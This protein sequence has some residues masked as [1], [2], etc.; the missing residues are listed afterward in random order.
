[1]RASLRRHSLLLFFVLAF[2]LSWWPWPFILL[3]PSSAPLLHFGVLFAALITVAV[4]HGRAGIRSLLAGVVRWRVKPRWYLVAL[5]LPAALMVGAAAVA[6]LLGKP[7][8][9]STLVEGSLVVPVALITTALAAGPLSEEP[10]WRGVALPAMIQRLGA[11]LGSV[12]LGVIW[13]LWH[14]P[15]LLTDPTG[16]REPIPYLVLLTSVSLVITWVYLASGRSL[17]IAILLHS[18]L[19][20]SAAAIF[21]AFQKPDWGLVWWLL[22]GAWVAVAAVVSVTVLRSAVERREPVGAEAGASSPA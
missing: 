10:G 17:L 21:P 8:S 20:T 9:S 14:L 18:M 15:V 11:V 19:N 3:N 13:A 12:V 22:A 4:T 7:I 2:A 1:M 6:V 16:Q 5:G